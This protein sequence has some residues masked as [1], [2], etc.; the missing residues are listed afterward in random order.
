MLLLL[1]CGGYNEGRKKIS[2]TKYLDNVYTVSV[3]ESDD[4]MAP[5]PS[6]RAG[7]DRRRKS[8]F[9]ESYEPVEDDESVEK[10]IHYSFY[11]HMVAM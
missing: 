10:V 11:L 3:T 9:A 2:P 5:P 1:G 7:M 6:Y 4:E 8:V